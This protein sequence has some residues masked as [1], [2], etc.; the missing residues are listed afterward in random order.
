MFYNE[1]FI[2]IVWVHYWW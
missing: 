2:Q 1:K